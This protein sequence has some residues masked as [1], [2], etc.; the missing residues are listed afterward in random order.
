[1][2][3]Y[4]NQT[5]LLSDE[6]AFVINIRMNTKLN[7]FIKRNQ[8]RN[9]HLYSN[10]LQEGI[11]YVVCPA[12]GQ[13]LLIIRTDYITKVLG[14]SIEQYDQ[15][16]PDTQKRCHAHK[17][18][19]KQGLHKFDPKTGLTRY[20]AGQV[21]ARETLKQIDE[22][23]V[24]GYTRKGQQTRNTHLRNIDSAG[25]NGYRRQADARITTVLE[26]GLTVEQNAHRKQKETLIKN[27]KTG[28]GGASKQSKKA[29]SPVIAFLKDHNI[30]FY[31]DHEEYG[32]KDNET[33]NYYFLDLTI[34]DYSIAIEY[35]S[36]A[37][38]ADPNLTETEWKNWKPP[39]GYPFTS[40]QVLT[41]DYNKA[42][43]LYKN[44]GIRTYYVWQKT[45]ETD[46]EEI[47][48]LLKT[49]ITKY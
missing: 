49:L 11:D 9:T 22:Y 21:K 45:Q 37:W 6:F 14:M 28:S 44:R 23:G 43:S 39:K 25:K 36:Y 38:H 30:K 40:Q 27:N 4:T 48:C 12:S 29:L 32:I 3:N 34:P 46:I 15:T 13:R 16:Y 41:Y 17:Q 42:R 26:N 20:E 35:Q 31:F 7:Q 33:G 19:I 1:M 24:S 8:K 47:I 10:G 18:N 5:K 2:S